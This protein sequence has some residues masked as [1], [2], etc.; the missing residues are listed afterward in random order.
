MHASCQNIAI[1]A[2]IVLFLTNQ[3]EGSVRDYKMNVI[4]VIFT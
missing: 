1:S 3:I 2:V 4:K